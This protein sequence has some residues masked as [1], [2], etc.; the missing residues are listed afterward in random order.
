MSFQGLYR[1]PSSWREPDLAAA[2]HAAL[3]YPEAGFRCEKEG[4]KPPEALASNRTAT[5][6]AV[7][8]HRDR[9]ARG[10]GSVL[11]GQDKGN[12]D[13]DILIDPMPETT[14]MDV[15]AIQL[16][17]QNLLGVSVDGLTPRALLDKF[18]SALLAEAVPV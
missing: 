10:F 3:V 4:M 13:L 12:S 18:R 2:L 17:L 16:E 7:E 6:Q 15:A 5:R 11:R 9:N 1:P 14:P 8:S